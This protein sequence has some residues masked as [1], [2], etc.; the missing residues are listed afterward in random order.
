MDFIR[1]ILIFIHLIAFAFAITTL[2]KSDIKLLYNKPNEVEVENLGKRMLMYLILL[3]ISGG[4]VVYVDTGFELNKILA[5]PKLLTKLTC[6]SVLT[7][8]AFVIHFVA[9]KKLSQ[10]TVNKLDMQIMSICGAVSTASWTYAG[11]LG[12][13]KPLVKYLTLTEFMSLYG[14]LLAG[15]VSGALVLTPFITKNWA[16]GE[17]SEQPQLPLRG[18]A[19]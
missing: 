4:G 5:A 13:A 6:V 3:W 10:Q 14:V 1:T 16:R 12:I 11:F 19:L 17:P 18:L 8:N 9:F 2:Y 7:L 15:A